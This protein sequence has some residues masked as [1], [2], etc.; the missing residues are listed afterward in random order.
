[1]SIHFYV[2]LVMSVEMTLATERNSNTASERNS[3][4]F[5]FFIYD[6]FMHGKSVL[7]PNIVLRNSSTYSRTCPCP[8]HS[9]LQYI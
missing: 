7:Y 2:I 1:M 3:I 6:G 9:Y 8:P 4:Q 5:M